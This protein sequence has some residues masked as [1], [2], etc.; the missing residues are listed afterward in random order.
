MKEP[1]YVGFS[2]SSVR[3]SEFETETCRAKIE[4]DDLRNLT[5]ES[6]VIIALAEYWGVSKIKT[7][8]LIQMGE[9]KRAVKIAAMNERANRCVC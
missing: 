8:G 3:F 2:A 1:N 6:P 7:Y 9:F 4:L 5:V